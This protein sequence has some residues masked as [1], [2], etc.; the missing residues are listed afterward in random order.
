MIRK[1]RNSHYMEAEAVL[2]VEHTPSRRFTLPAPVTSPHI[3]RKQNIM[4]VKGF[5]HIPDLTK[6]VYDKRYDFVR[7]L[8]RKTNNATPIK[9]FALA[10]LLNISRSQVSALRRACWQEGL[11]VAMGPRGYFYA[12][13]AAELMPIYEQVKSR[14]RAEQ[15]NENNLAK[16]I[17]A[18][19]GRALVNQ[20]QETLTL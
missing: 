2:T 18:M 3:L 13:T 16:M 4:A 6:R 14:R 9:G 15:A 17:I 8:K 20:E 10:R 1:R 11:Q 12:W 7:I 19:G 5:E